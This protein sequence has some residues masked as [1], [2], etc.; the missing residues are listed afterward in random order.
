MG[1]GFQPM[2]P[3]SNAA[4]NSLGYQPGQS[5]TGAAQ[6]AAARQA[7][8][9]GGAG[10]SA[11]NPIAGSGFSGAMN[12]TD[13]RFWM[14]GQAPANYTP[15]LGSASTYAGANGMNAAAQGAQGGLLAQLQAQAAGKGPSIATQA[16][17]QQTGQNIR[18]QAALAAGNPNNPM[19]AYA[20]AQNAGAMNQQGAGQAAM[21]RAQEQLNAQGALAG[22]A[23]QMQGQSFQ[24]A[25]L[26]QQAGLANMDASNQ[27][28]LQQAGLNQQ[29]T[30]AYN[31]MIAQQ[32]GAAN[33][34]IYAQQQASQQSDL[35]LRNQM[36]GGA[37]SGLSS[38][39][40]T[41]A[42]S[43]ER[44]KTD[45][46]DGTGLIHALLDRLGAHDYRYKHPGAPGEAEGRFTSPMA[47]EMEKSELGAR[48]VHD[49][50]T[51]K[52]VDTGPHTVAM[53][54]SALADLHERTK[55]L[56]GGKRSA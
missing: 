21:A 42:K 1:T 43:D 54:L 40:G 47:Q 2:D 19:A 31:S 9:A 45:V 36:I 23:G 35:Q 44:A 8:G 16:L 33:Q 3:A 48:L 11:G 53:M 20:G 18:Q 52:M 38:V 50:P 14:G 22:L 10:G 55:K 5:S 28:A 39:A 41:L 37:V 51:G 13:P 6:A 4:M 32:Q 30:E 27:F 25:G 46:Q 15:T 17:Q 24:Q 29:G 7:S 26:T 56:E 49:T 12:G 34:N